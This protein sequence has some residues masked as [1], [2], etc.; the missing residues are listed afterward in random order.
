MNK[1]LK[2]QIKQDDLVTGVRAGRGLRAQRTSTRSRSRWRRSWWPCWRWAGFT[3]YRQARA[4][5]TRSARSRLRSSHVRRAGRR[6]TRRRTQ[7][8]APCASRARREKFKKAAAEF[9]GV[10]RRYGSMA[11]GRRA[12]Y[13]AALCRVGAGG[14]GRG[15]EGARRSCRSATRRPLER[16]TRAAGAGRRSIAG[17]ARSTRPIDDV[18]ADRRRRRAG[19]AARPR[20]DG[21]VAARSRMRERLPEAGASYRRVADEFPTSVYAAEARAARRLPAGAPAADGR[22]RRSETMKKRTAWILVACVAAGRDRRR[23]RGRARARCCA[24]AAAAAP[25]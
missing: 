25:R 15:R 18:P 14:D 16:G 6:E 8:P 10:D 20:A 23:R 9:D 22:G 11:A 21:A 3:Y 12:R 7:R 24:A 2:H 1:E 4:R 13:Y 5:P 19:R 17:P